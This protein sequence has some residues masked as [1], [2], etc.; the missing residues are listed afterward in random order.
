MATPRNSG[1]SMEPL[2]FDITK[3]GVKS[4]TMP[5]F[6]GGKNITY[7]S[8]SS[9]LYKAF[10]PSLVINQMVRAIVFFFWI[11]PQRF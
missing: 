5:D 4:G 6:W 7:Y 2:C 3:K 1:C 10:G 8:N 9:F 11:E